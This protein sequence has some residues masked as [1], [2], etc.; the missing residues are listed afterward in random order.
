M[1]KKM[2]KNSVIA[3]S[4]LLKENLIYISDRKS[5]GLFVYDV[6]SR[7]LKFLA[8]LSEKEDHGKI[9]M[10]YKILMYEDELI[11]VP[12]QAHSLC[13]YNITFGKVIHIELP[14][15]IR[16][17]ECKF[18]AA[19]ILDGKLYMFG[20]SV[21]IMLVLDME[22][23][24]YIE[25]SEINNKLKTHMSSITDWFFLSSVDD[26]NHIY[27]VSYKKNGI[28]DI[29]IKS[30]NVEYKEIEEI[31]DG[32]LYVQKHKGYLIIFPEKSNTFI[33]Y[34]IQTCKYDALICNSIQEDSSHMA[35]IAIEDKVYALP[36]M[37]DKFICLNTDDGSLHEIKELAEF[38]NRKFVIDNVVKYND[39]IIFNRRSLNELI[40]YNV[41][42][43]KVEIIKLVTEEYPVDFCKK[44]YEKNIITE[45]IDSDLEYFMGYLRN[46]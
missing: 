8:D 19:N 6:E 3:N 44:Y 28:F 11:F 37:A 24:E 46:N 20:C 41:I 10:Y 31:R 23:K 13:V 12:Y 17:A 30:Q 15:I 36:Y 45:R 5:G 34:N 38:A 35:S 1:L 42:N 26:E 27:A 7:Y 21:N 43:G 2:M 33:R 40:K 18:I 22:S 39:C 29:D 16:N 14:E 9:C 32:G 4:M 25:C